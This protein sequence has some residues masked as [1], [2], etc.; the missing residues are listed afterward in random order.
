MPHDDHS[1]DHDHGH[2]HVHPKRRFKA[3]VDHLANDYT[4]ASRL[5]VTIDAALM[6]QSGLAP[7]G[8]VRVATER[9]R[10]VL[11]RLG[12][13][14]PA[15]RGRGILRMDRF[16]RQA[17]KAH[18][19]E[20]VEVEP[21]ELK[22]ATV[23]ELNPAIDVSTAHNLVPHLKQ[24]LVANRTPLS[25]GA[26]LY[27]SF[28]GTQAGTTY[29]VHRLPD[30]VGYVTEATEIKLHFHDEHVPEGAFEVTFEDV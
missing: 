28:P 29:E 8:I 1:H 30:G 10:S 17:L 24:V 3:T 13:P 5:I 9:G 19:N 21:A 14:V 7:D 18:L 15:D 4:I 12:E 26:V 11:A 6:H 2:V 23:V 27:I 20:T 16:L 25:V 22:P